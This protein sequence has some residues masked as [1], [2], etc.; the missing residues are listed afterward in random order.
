[1]WINA[2]LL[3]LRERT[4]AI[5]ENLDY[6]LTRTK[7]S[8][9]SI[10]LIKGI[11]GKIQSSQQ[12]KRRSITLPSLTAQYISYTEQLLPDKL[13]ICIDELDKVTDGESVRAILQLGDVPLQTVGFWGSLG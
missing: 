5:S 12:L 2:L 8:E 6:E 4:D 13:I 10:P 7:Q 1:M 9:L 3:W 11:A